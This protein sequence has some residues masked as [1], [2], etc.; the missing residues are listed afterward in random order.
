MK[1][2]SSKSG[3]EMTARRIVDMLGSPQT[4][5]WG[6]LGIL[7]IVGAAIR[8]RFAGTRQFWGDE[9]HNYEV[10]NVTR[11]FREFI[12][13]WWTSL[14]MSDPP[15]Y[16]IFCWLNV[17]GESSQSELRLRLPS[18]LFGTLCIPL[19]YRV[20][21]RFESE[22]FSLL[23][24][25]LCATS[26]FSIQY[27]QEYRP[28]SLLM[29][30]ALVLGDSTSLL[31]ERFS[32]KRL[33]YFSLSGFVA[34]YTHFFGGFALAGCFVMWAWC[35]LRS[36]E[37][38]SIGRR[39]AILGIVPVFLTLLYIPM[40]IKGRMLA[41]Y[42]QGSEAT[43]IARINLAHFLSTKANHNYFA[44]LFN[45]FAVYRL[46][47]L[48]VPTIVLTAILG[49]L[50]I[51]RGALVRRRLCIGLVIWL[52]ATTVVTWAFYELMRYPYDA[53]RN[54][55]QLPVFLYF[56]AGGVALPWTL[57][58][59]YGGSG[60]A[61]KALGLAASLLLLGGLSFVNLNNYR[62]YAAD[63][64]RDENNQADWRSMA[65]YVAKMA[66][67]E[68][69]VMIPIIGDTWLRLHYTFYQMV[70]PT[71][72]E[73]SYPST[74]ADVQKVLREGR[75]G[76]FIM[77]LPHTI[78]PDLFQYLLNRGQWKSYFGGAVVF[79]PPEPPPG[80]S[81]LK[82]QLLAVPTSRG[83]ALGALRGAVRGDLLLTG[84][85]TRAALHF[86]DNTTFALLKL[87]QG[88]HE[89]TYRSTVPGVGETTVGLMPVV[90]PGEWQ[91]AVDFSRLDPSSSAVWF[92]LKDGQPIVYMQHNGS[93]YYNFT[94]AAGG[95]FDLVLEA[96]EDKPGPIGVRV[97]ASGFGETE[98]FVFDAKDNSFRHRNTGCG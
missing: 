85:V 11:T 64:W 21:R 44:N 51:L 83:A 71:A 49:C 4:V 24:A 38:L 41:G 5:R 68:D 33:L 81:P 23:A 91:P 27:S 56:V 65:R 63:G 52:A 59:R 34:I 43:E 79:L 39:L 28:Y 70:Y 12:S 32:W 77:A 92:K 35:L 67:P 69:T 88:V 8:F 36:P 82:K 84:P 93:L 87:P 57:A 66:R 47:P 9:I 62:S 94:L 89:L 18:L 25:G 54:I 3:Q 42:L 16:Y 80:V 58:A 10:G 73:K 86:D 48:D 1:L 14:A 31:C 97:F 76:W 40:I 37:N 22:P 17:S 50:G 95:D 46:G 74:L 90:K 98:R 29:L 78:P 15:F 13:A 55:F 60:R 61:V 53:R 6:V 20:V 96:R 7:T 72:A 19:L 26:V 45:S 75:A 2:N 30:L